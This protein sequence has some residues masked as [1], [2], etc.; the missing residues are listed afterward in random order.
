MA[1]D[2]LKFRAT[3][4]SITVARTGSA[5]MLESLLGERLAAAKALFE[6]E[7]YDMAFPDSP[8]ATARRYAREAEER[9]RA[10]TRTMLLV[11][12]KP[13]PFCNGRPEWTE[14]DEG[15]GE[16]VFLECTSCNARGPIRDDDTSYGIT[17]VL[18]NERYVSGGEVED[19]GSGPTS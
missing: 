19:G 12:A 7:M 16:P 3:E 5:R 14:N 6:Q 4:A 13:C 10:A 9:A 2:E 18:W 11:G 17:L 8:G 15:C 1:D